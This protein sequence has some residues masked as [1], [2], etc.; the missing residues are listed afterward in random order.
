MRNIAFSGTLRKRS[1]PVGIFRPG[2]HGCN[3]GPT[4]S[5]IKIKNFGPGPARHEREIEISA[6]AK[7]GPKLNAKF[8]PGPD[9]DNFFFPISART[10]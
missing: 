2:P 1:A 6:R 7:R 8:W 10:A 3:L 5:E 9:P 4:R